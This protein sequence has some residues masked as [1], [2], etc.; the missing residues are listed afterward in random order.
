MVTVDD[1]ASPVRPTWCTGCGNFAIWNAVKRALAQVGLAPHQ[2]MLVSGI[3]CG[4]KLPDYTHANGYM[5]LHGRTVPVA[6]GVRLANHGLRVI[7]THGDGDAYAEGL[8]HMLH[9]AR[10]N[11]GL[12]DIIQDNRIYGLTKGQYSPTSDRGRVSKTSPWGSFELPVNPIA[13]A[14]AAGATFV[15][16]SWS[17]DL[18]HLTETIVRALGHRGYALIDVFQPCVTFNRQNS[19]DYYRPR[20]Y[21]LQDDPTYDVTDK[22]AAFAKAL[23]W[24]D[25]IPIG[26]FY[27][28]EDRPAYEEQ[29]PALRAGPLAPRPL[30]KLT[31]EQV[32]RLLEEAM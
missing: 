19:Y 25:R 29:V 9:A 18:N 32:R 8:G 13:L 15:A 21:N 23:E 20:V 3:G 22:M 30:E 12:V 16:R 26:V 5:T 17:G 7:C 11:I 28:V 27:Q 10:R 1:F 6:T 24:G 31:P 4:S 14:L 2:V